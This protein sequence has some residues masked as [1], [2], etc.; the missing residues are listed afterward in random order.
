MTSAMGAEYPEIHLRAS[1]QKQVIDHT[2]QVRIRVDLVNAGTFAVARC[3]ENAGPDQGE[4]DLQ[5]HIHDASGHVPRLTDHGER[6]FYPHRFAQSTAGSVQCKNFLPGE[7]HSE[8]ILLNTLYV[9]EPG[10]TYD[11]SF[12]QMPRKL[13]FNGELFKGRVDS[14]WV[15]VTVK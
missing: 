15:T 5:I 3:Q 11:A 12:T 8:T 1:P 6:F 10:H 7:V 13:G 9:L 4:Y 2:Q 14:N